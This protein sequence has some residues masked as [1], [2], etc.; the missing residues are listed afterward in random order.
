[1]LKSFWCLH[2]LSGFN[3]NT[4]HK[5]RTFKNVFPF[6]KQRTFYQ[7]RKQK[8][9]NYGLVLNHFHSCFSPCFQSRIVSGV[10]QSS[11]FMSRYYLFFKK[12]FCGVFFLSITK[13]ETPNFV[14]NSFSI[15]RG[16]Q[17]CGIEVRKPH[18]HDINTQ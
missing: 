2:F 16:S 3:F 12:I 13:P 1:M 17:T 11:Y 14:F 4:V 15:I 10:T 18:S 6:I 7:I 5:Y 8:C 9:V